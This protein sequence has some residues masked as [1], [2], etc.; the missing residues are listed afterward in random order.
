MAIISD[1]A[2]TGISLQADK[3]VENKR[4]RVHITA[5]LAWSA[6]KTVR[7]SETPHN[8]AVR[9]AGLVGRSPF[10][11]RSISLSLAATFT[12]FKATVT[13]C[14]YCSSLFLEHR[15][16]SFGFTAEFEVVSGIFS[17]RD[18]IIMV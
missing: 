13:S 16:S 2:S 7:S 8:V 9:A 12:Y 4:L 18:S 5:E 15:N 3:A 11:R 10:L 1:A 14:T 6:D 17:R